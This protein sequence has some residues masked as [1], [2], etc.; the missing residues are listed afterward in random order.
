M[1]KF[2]ILTTF[3][4]FFLGHSLISVSGVCGETLVLADN[5]HGEAL[6]RRAGDIMVGD[7]LVTSDCDGV[8]APSTVVDIIPVE[9]KFF[10][11]FELESSCLVKNKLKEALCV[12]GGQKLLVL[13]NTLK[14]Y[15]E[16]IVCASGVKDGIVFDEMVGCDDQESVLDRFA[17]HIPQGIFCMPNLLKAMPVEDIFHLD[18]FCVVE[19]RVLGKDCF[20]EKVFYHFILD[21]P[22]AAILATELNVL[23]FSSSEEGPSSREDEYFSYESELSSQE[24]EC[25]SYGGEPLGEIGAVPAPREVTLGGFGFQPI[26][27]IDCL[28]FSKS[29]SVDLPEEDKD[30]DLLRLMSDL[31]VEFESWSSPVGY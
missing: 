29:L 21:R 18:S 24:S 23:C 9:P 31:G 13:D 20:E 2:R 15:T 25:S 30:V 12:C 19:K 27:E 8:I 3:L 22:T 6:Y 28:G 17:K 1:G 26:I 4:L 16:K 10:V 5:G 14:Y 11:H 7:M